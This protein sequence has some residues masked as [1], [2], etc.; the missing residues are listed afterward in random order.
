MPGQPVRQAALV[1]RSLRV[2]VE[3]WLLQALGLIV[4]G[5]LLRRAWTT[6]RWDSRPPPPPMTADER[7]A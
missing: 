1:H 2:V 7:K 4:V 5:R 3:F 6:Y